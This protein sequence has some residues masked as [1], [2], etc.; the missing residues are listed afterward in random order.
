[1]DLI[2][3]YKILNRLR[4]ISESIQQHNFTHLHLHTTYSF[5]DG[6]NRPE[7]SAARAKELG[8]KAMAVTDHNHLCGVIDFQ[9][10]CH[11]EGVKPL[12][13]FE[14]YWTWDTDILSM[15]ADE[16]TEWAIK[17]ARED[18]VE[19]PDKVNGKKITKTQLKEFIADYEY[20]NSQ[21]HILFIALNQT[22]W[23]NIVKLQSEAAAKCTFNKRYLVDTKMMAKYSEGIMMTTACVHNIVPEL[24]NAGR[25]EEAE[26]ILKDWHDIF[27]E[28]FYVEIQPNNFDKQWTAN[29]KLINWA[30]E[31]DVKIVATNDVHYTRHEDHED[32]D[33]LFV[34]GIGARKDDPDRMRY[35]DNYW[36]RDYDEMLE[37]FS[38]QIET[39]QQ[40]DFYG[41]ELFDVDSYIETVVEALGNTNK[42]AE[43]VEEIKLGSSKPLMPQLD[44]PKG[45]AAETYLTQACYKNLY[46]Y[47]NEHPEIDLRIYEKRLF[48]ELNIINP[49]GYAPYM[50][51]VQEY[52]DW[53]N[54]NGCPTGP[55]RGSAAGSLV[56]FLLGVTKQIDPIKYHLLFFRFL[57][58]DRTSPPDVDV[59][60]DYD[61]RY[62]I[63]EHFED[64]YG[65]DHVA[66]IGTY[67]GLGVKSGIKD[68]G[69]VLEIPFNEVNEVNKQLDEI[70]TKPSVKFEDFDKL[71]EEDPQGY[72]QFHALEEQYPE[73]FRLARRFEGVYRQVGVHASGVLVTPMPVT[74]LFPTRVAK[75]GTTVTLYTGSQLEDLNALKFDI[76]GLKTITII[77]NCLKHIDEDLSF[78]DLYKM[79]DLT[80]SGM[81][82]MIREKNTG[83][84]FQIESNLFRGLIDDIQPTEFNDMIVMTSVARPGPLSAGMHTQY[85]NRKHGREEAVEVLPQTWDI[86]EDSLGVIAYQEQLMR[87]SQ[88]VAKFDDNQADTYLRKAVAKKKKEKMDLCRQ[89][90]IY[91]KR[92]EPAPA[93]YDSSNKDQPMYDPDGHYGKPVLGGIQNGYDETELQTFW[94]NI[95]GFASYLFNLSH[96]ACYTYITALT[97]WL[98]RYYPV[99][100]MAALLSMEEAED[101]SK[102]YINETEAMGISISVPN[103]N[104]SEKDFT[105]ITERKEILFGLGSV[106]GV[107]DKSI[108]AIIENRPYHSLEELLEKVPKK[109]LNKTVG[110]ALIK[111]GA[112]D[113][114]SENRYKLMNDFFDIR[115]DKDERF[116]DSNYDTDACVGF[117]LE[118]LGSAITFKPWW[119]EIDAGQTFTRQ[120]HIDS[121]NE[122]TD[123]NNRLMAFVTLSSSNCKVRG[124]VFA[125]QYSKFIGLL[126]PKVN[127][128]ALITGKKDDKGGFIVNKVKAAPKRQAHEDKEA[129]LFADRFAGILSV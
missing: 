33:T 100:F 70:L 116:D 4:K 92:N 18:G 125:S 55:G 2:E 59:D 10:A 75:D 64:K 85:A 97:A 77:K 35:E 44:V 52:V 15:S 101:K 91:G 50:L 21:Y 63:I 54:A 122:R 71:K 78:E 83:G 43:E 106:K 28:H 37:A 24:F 40:E 8:M 9:E 57:T 46:K 98:K 68:V 76:L 81:F 27:G 47:K 25:D 89:W 114:F 11:E 51:M 72:K 60:F 3:A 108:P 104:I 112:C 39:M 90:F 124:V 105:P 31:H 20:D 62:R 42:I 128:T 48:D 6:F 127:E 45:L 19:V 16:R 95:E 86:V 69:R 117:E 7:D 66:H 103:V 80:D 129:D 58:A 56:L 94:S 17:R 88:R 38:H 102:R 93:G 96:A 12:L 67:S 30:R 111:C 14:G 65:K 36:I 79:V 115:K 121:V 41:K 32:H 74:D 126:D 22:G 113:S 87:I 120:F 119:D 53:A 49:K 26:A 99:E 107:G 110:R 61:N 23:K 73:L 29:V 5:L 34:I 84:V 1:M 118:T 109:Q 13:G 123:R 82:E